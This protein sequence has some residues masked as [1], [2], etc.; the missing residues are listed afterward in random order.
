MDTTP[1]AVPTYLASIARWAIATGAGFLIG[2]GYVTA[3]QAATVSAAAL[4]LLPL[5][6]SLIQKRNAGK[7]LKDA[8]AAPAGL[9][10]PL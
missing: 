10:K 6:W 9:T 1:G 7:A 2:K 4:A 5:A 8:I 3:E